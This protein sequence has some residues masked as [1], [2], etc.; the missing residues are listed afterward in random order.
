MNGQSGFP[1]HLCS[2]QTAH[3]AF[4]NKKWLATTTILQLGFHIT[5]IAV[6]TIKLGIW[7]YSLCQ[8]S[9]IIFGTEGKKQLFGGAVTLDGGYKK[10]SAHHYGGAVWMTTMIELCEHC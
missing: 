10:K 1:L 3:T 8:R 5:G 7:W 9:Q 4:M 2:A 6:N